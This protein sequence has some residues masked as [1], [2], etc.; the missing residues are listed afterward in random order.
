M[1]GWEPI[2]GETP[3]DDLSGFKRFHRFPNLTRVVINNL[4]AENIRKA[5]VKY[6]SRKPTKSSAPFSYAWLLRLHKE[7][8]GDVWSWAGAPRQTA[9]NVGV[10]A[11]QIPEALQGMLLNLAH[12]ENS[13]SETETAALLH[14]RAVQIH[15]FLNGNGR[16]AR[17]LANIWLKKNGQALTFWP[18]DIEHATQ[19]RAAYLAALRAA[20]DTDLAPLTALHRRFTA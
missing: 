17:M 9:T 13:L 10:P 19:Y 5:T 11:F 2:E 15:P 18:T 4:E 1:P 8:Y 16:W 12:W 6:L 14:H 3:Q 7:M 20:D